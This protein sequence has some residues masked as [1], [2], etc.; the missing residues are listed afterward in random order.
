MDDELRQLLMD[1]EQAPSSLALFLV[2]YRFLETTR[3]WSQTHRIREE[4][5]QLL[6]DLPLCRWKAPVLGSAQGAMPTDLPSY[7]TEAVVSRSAGGTR[8]DFAIRLLAGAKAIDTA[9]A[10]V[11]PFGPP[12]VGELASFLPLRT[13]LRKGL[14]LYSH[15]GFGL[16]PSPRQA[17]LRSRRGQ[18]IQDHFDYLNVVPMAGEVPIDYAVNASPT[19]WAGVSPERVAILPVV[20][21][22]GEVEW[23]LLGADTYRVRLASTHLET[24]ATRLEEALEW[25]LAKEPEVVLLPELVGDPRLDARIKRYLSRRAT[26]GRYVPTLLL[27]GSVMHD[28]GDRTTNRARVIAGDGGELWLQDKMHAYEFTLEEQ[29]NANWPFQERDPVLR[30]ECIDIDER[31]LTVF[32]LGPHLRC[33]VLICEDF[34]QAMSLRALEP[35]DV[36]LFLVPVMN[37]PLGAGDWAAARAVQLADRPGSASIVANSGVLVSDPAAGSAAATTADRL[38]HAIGS[39]RKEVDW[40]IFPDKPGVHPT[41]IFG[42]LRP[43]KSP[44]S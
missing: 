39:P 19:G 32:D 5:Q 36:T 43:Y 21:H 11:H 42:T 22:A 40:E 30:M 25:V 17:I 37:G 14:P 41:A 13:Q 16:F 44:I 20:V 24:I 12:A 4:W 6:R 28:D 9:F 7:F 10:G 35:W 34:K 1:I 26:D 18:E 38:A 3:I 2:V 27:C 31:K 23:T 8:R 33:A 29:A 15:G